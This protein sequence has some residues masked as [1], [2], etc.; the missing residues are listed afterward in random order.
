MTWI[1]ELKEGE[2]DDI[3][4]DAASQMASNAN[5]GG[6]DEQIEF[7]TVIGGWTEEDIRKAFLD[8]KVDD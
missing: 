4:H 8:N 7:L 2:L 3:V 5:N 6:V 1:D